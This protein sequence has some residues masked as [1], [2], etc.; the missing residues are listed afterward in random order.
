MIMMRHAKWNL[1]LLLLPAMCAF[2]YSHTVFLKEPFSFPCDSSKCNKAE[3]KIGDSNHVIA[4]YSNALWTIERDFTQDFKVRDNKL[5]LKA[6][7]YKDNGRYECVCDQE[8]NQIVLQ[9]LYALNI[10]VTEGENITLPCHGIIADKTDS[11]GYQCYINSETKEGYPH[12]Y[13]LHYKDKDV[14]TPDT[15]CKEETYKIPTVILSI[16]L[17]CALWLFCIF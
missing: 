17:L 10:Q 7:Q 4:R 13:F 12:S 2:N 3:L 8:K 6:A 1:F 16:V 5:L 9:V 15:S 11:G 14:K